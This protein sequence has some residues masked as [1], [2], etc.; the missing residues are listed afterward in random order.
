M[1]EATTGEKCAIIT[2]G[3]T[4]KPVC[5]ANQSRLD[6]AL[7]QYRQDGWNTKSSRET[8]DSGRFTLGQRD[9]LLFL[10]ENERS[11]YEYHNQ[12][13]MAYN[14]AKNLAVN[15]ANGRLVTPTGTSA[16]NLERK[17]GLDSAQVDEVV[18]RYGQLFRNLE[19][20]FPAGTPNAKFGIIREIESQISRVE[21]GSALETPLHVASNEALQPV[22]SVPDAR[23]KSNVLTV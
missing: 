14:T 11:T 21:R 3:K 16:I 10:L 22:N 9:A 13:G 5:R 19:A 7:D 2:D 12:T 8:G 1:V 17:F 4:E 18:N 20:K 15:A 23:T 6:A